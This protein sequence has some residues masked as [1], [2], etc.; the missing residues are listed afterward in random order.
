[1]IRTGEWGIVTVPFA[2]ST[3]R[4]KACKGFATLVL[5]HELAASSV[6]KTNDNRTLDF[7]NST[8]ASAEGGHSRAYCRADCP[9]S[10]GFLARCSAGD[11]ARPPRGH[12]SCG[13]APESH[14]LRCN[15]TGRQETSARAGYK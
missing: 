14:R 6:M 11:L 10:E 3:L 2:A 12:H 13:T 4:G 1:M 7:T 15:Y 8:S 9:S 5:A